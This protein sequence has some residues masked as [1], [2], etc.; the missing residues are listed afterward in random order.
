MG[1]KKVKLKIS[2]DETWYPEIEVD[3]HLTDEEILDMVVNG[4]HEDDDRIYDDYQN[5]RTYDAD[6]YTKIDKGEE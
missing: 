1:K 5:K 2:R 6:T 3:D 4:D